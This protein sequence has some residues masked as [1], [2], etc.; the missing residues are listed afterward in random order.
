MLSGNSGDVG[1]TSPKNLGCQHFLVDFVNVKVWILGAKF[2]PR[3]PIALIN[4]SS[5][6][7]K[8]PLF[9]PVKQPGLWQFFRNTEV[10]LL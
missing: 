7:A 8:G 1:G 5:C 10:R 9:P 4:L 3:N 6:L 2:S